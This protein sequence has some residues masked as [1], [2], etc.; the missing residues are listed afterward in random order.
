MEIRR[1]VRTARGVSP[2]A[3]TGFVGG[4]VPWVD[5]TSRARTRRLDELGAAPELRGVCMAVRLEEDNHWLVREDVLRGLGAVAERG[6]SVDGLVE[7]RH[8]PSVGRLE[9]RL[10][11]LSIAV[12]HRGGPVIGRGRP[13]P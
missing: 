8:L 6:L 11:G 3:G 10:P 9:A 1:A 12:C 7:P 13:E 5:G 2:A 4:V